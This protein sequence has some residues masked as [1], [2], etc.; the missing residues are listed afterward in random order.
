M[1]CY[2]QWSRRRVDV[3]FDQLQISY[4]SDKS[5]DTDDQI[6]WVSWMVIQRKYFAKKRFFMVMMFGFHWSKDYICHNYD[7]AD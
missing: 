1:N 6:L 5:N 7:E 4:R 2:A 3:Y